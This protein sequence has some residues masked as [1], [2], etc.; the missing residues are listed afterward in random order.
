MIDK[1]IQNID[2][3]HCL[4]KIAFEVRELTSNFPL[5]KECEHEML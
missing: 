3:D 1:A 4:D 2:D 5:H